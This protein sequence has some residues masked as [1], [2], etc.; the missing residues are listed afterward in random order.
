MATQYGGVVLASTSTDGESITWTAFAA[1]KAGSVFD[2]TRC[3]DCCYVGGIGLPLPSKPP[4][5]GAIELSYASS[6]KP[7]GTLAP[8]PDKLHGSWHLNVFGLGGVSDYEPAYVYSWPEGEDIDVKAAG[9]E[10]QAFSGRLQTGRALGDVQPSIEGA[11]VPIDRASGFTVTWEPEAR[12]QMV[13]LL[14]QQFAN[15][16]GPSACFC[17]A[18]DSGGQLTVSPDILSK[19]GTEPGDISLSRSNVTNVTSGNATIALVGE[20]EVTGSAEF[21]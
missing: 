18:P 14:L 3:Q 10:V 1:F 17:S 9:N 2:A 7:L 5:A 13:T 11:T 20:V 4:D 8:S 21:R 6:E 19:F 12:E 15:M 16:T